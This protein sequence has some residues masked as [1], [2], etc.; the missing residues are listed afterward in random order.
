MSVKDNLARFK[1]MTGFGLR[2]FGVAFAGRPIETIKAFRRM[3]AARSRRIEGLTRAVEGAAKSNSNTAQLAS[4][5]DAIA[6]LG[7]NYSLLVLNQ[8]RN[9]AELGVA[10]LNFL[11]AVGHIL[12]M[13][14]QAT[15][16]ISEINVKLSAQE[17]AKLISEA[18]SVQINFKDGDGL[19]SILQIEQYVPVGNGD[20]TSLNDLNVIMRRCGAPVFES[21]GIA[22]AR[23]L[24]GAGIFEDTVADQQI[25][26]VLT[27]V[28]H[29]DT[30][31]QESYATAR[32]EAGDLD[33]DASSFSRFRNNDE[34]RFSLRSLN[35]YAPWLRKIYIFSN[36][37]PPPW[38][39]VDD[40]KIVYVRHEEVMPHDILPTFNSHVIE[41]YLHKIP[42]LSERFIYL[43]DDFFVMQ[44]SVPSDYFGGSG[45]SYSRLEPYGVVSGERRIGDPDYLNA[46]RNVAALLREKAGYV[47]TQLHRH[48]PYS[49]L[50]S[51]LEEME[52]EWA[53]EYA[54][55][56]SNKFR[57]LNDLNIPS[58]MYHH[59]A[60]GAGR[61]ED[62]PCVVVLI[63]S[64]DLAT[65]GARFKRSLDAD[66]MFVCINEGGVEAPPAD[67]YGRVRKFMIER[68]PNAASWE[69]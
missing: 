32:R 61:A 24:L 50:R 4:L 43:N 45:R 60:I 53:T 63:K 16:Y 54:S 30:A 56:R 41:S 22:Y 64:N 39:D 3:A 8:S 34:L 49:L 12:R 9:K 31:W 2:D 18:Q 40:K 51:V 15:L 27:W 20:W 10:D 47:P 11:S 38:L 46:S 69:L 55:F 1:S 26:A 44:P 59:Y 37:P 29:T 6:Q 7:E 36:C 14:P 66:T 33:T 62:R 28:D 67:W 13:F 68:F 17:S 57:D 65:Q 5:N 48:A 23:D 42:D 25:D 52:Q 19:R 35:D 21:A 58:F